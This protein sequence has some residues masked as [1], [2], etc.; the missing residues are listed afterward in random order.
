MRAGG[1][2]PPQFWRSGARIVVRLRERKGRE[3]KRAD[4]E[5]KDREERWVGRE[6][7]PEW[8]EDIDG[9]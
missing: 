7:R 8:K 2:P 4:D 5:M 9:K 6:E 1:T 3:N